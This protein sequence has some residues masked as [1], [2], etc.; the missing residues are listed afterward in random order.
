MYHDMEN[1]LSHHGVKGQKWGV[2]NDK[3]H[4]GQRAKTKKI[5]KKDKRFAKNADNPILQMQ[6][7]NRAAAKTNEVD[8]PRINNKPQY[9]NADFTRD[10]PLRQKYYK[11]HQDAW[12]NRLEEAANSLGTNASGTKKYGIIDH[13]DM[14]W[15]VTLRDIKHDGETI[16]L[17]LTTDSTGH[18][19]EIQ[20]IDPLI[21]SGIDVM[22]AILSHYGVK[23]QKW[24]VRRK[25]SDRS[26]SGSGKSAKGKNKSKEQPQRFGKE[27]KRL[28]DKELNARI[29]RMELEK[30][31]NDL[32]STSKTSSEGKTIASRVLK[33]V[34]E[35]TSTRILNDVAYYAGKKAIE[36]ALSKQMGKESASKVAKDIFPKKK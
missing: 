32:N 19:I 10:T 34:G 25:R 8:V 21:Q 16:Q 33:N 20:P 31:Y 7:Y 6:I 15:E 18:I 13:G 28:S 35:Q 9:K 29:K 22:E 26:S 30:K 1:F 27:A 5:V 23:G 3:G 11:E 12:V 2:R 14:R 17:E 36:L 24:G 4:E